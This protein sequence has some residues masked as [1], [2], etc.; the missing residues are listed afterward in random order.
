MSDS[1]EDI[2]GVS[3]L[4]TP[5][6]TI[7]ISTAGAAAPVVAPA[8]MQYKTG[9]KMEKQAEAERVRVRKAEEEKQAKL[10]AEVAAE[11]KRA[12]L[13]MMTRMKRKGYAG[14]VYAGGRTDILGS[15]IR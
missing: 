3:L 10:D 7:G 9:K 2:M 8:A 15:V 12:N 1:A 13:E 11:K 5:A 4:S 14:T 6:A